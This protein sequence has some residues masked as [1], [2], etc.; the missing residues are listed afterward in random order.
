MKWKKSTSVLLSV[1]LAGSTFT[2]PAFAASNAET[3]KPLS[4]SNVLNVNKEEILKKV[5]ESKQQVLDSLFK[6][7]DNVRV[8]VEVAGES[9]IEYATKKNLSYEELPQSTKENL[10]NTA[11]ATQDSVQAAIESRGIDLQVANT[12]TTVI[13]GF[14]GEVKYAD[15]AKI[16]ELPNVTN[17]QISE[18]YQRPVSEP[19]MNTSH[20]FIQS[21]Q[22]WAD[23]QYKGEGQVIAVIDTGVDPGHKDFVLS[24]D[25]EEDLTQEEV[26]T[27]ITEKGLPGKFHTEKVPYGYN[28]FDKNQEILDLGPAASMHGM[29]V[30]GTT[31][32]NGEIKGVAPEAQVLAMKVFSNDPEY[33]STYEDIYIT[34][35]DDAIELGADVINMSLGSTASFYREDALSNKAITKATQNGIVV[36]VSAGNAGHIGYGWSTYPLAKNPDI[37]V[38][39]APGLS[40]DSLQVAATGNEMFLYEHSFTVNGETIKGNG[41]D[42]WT[43]LNSKGI[44]VVS[45]GGK[46]GYPAD[47]AGVDIKGKVVLVQR[48]TLSFY[49]K[50]RYATEAGAAGIIVYSQSPTSTHN[51]DQGGWGFVPFMLINNASGLILEAAIT[52][53]GGKL[54]L[55]VTESSKLE[56]PTMGKMTDFTSWGTTPTLEIKPEI[57]AP[58]GNIY[59]TFQNNTYGYMSGTSMAAPHVAGGSAL[60]M[61]FL[62]QD[63]P[64]LSKEESARAAK[65]RLM[66]TAKIIKDIYNNPFSPRRQG[67]GMM[68]TYAAVTTPVTVVRK[69]TEVGKVELKDF[70]AK[71]FSFT[72]EATND[73][74]EAVTYSVNTDVLTDAI[75]TKYNLTVAEPMKG[76]VVSAPATIEVPA[77]GKKEF[78]ISV[79]LTNA[80]I[81][82][83]NAQGAPVELDLKEDIFVEGFVRLEHATKPDL[84]IPYVGFYGKWDRPDIIDGFR[85]LGEA[86]FYN[87]QE[88]RELRNDG[89][90]YLFGTT[91]SLKY[92]F[93]PNGDNYSDNIQP[94]M[95]FLRNAKEVEYNILDKDGKQLRSIF[96][97]YDTRKS[98]YNA[99]RSL[100]YNYNMNR[101]WDGTIKF[102]KVPDGEYIYEIKAVLD[103]PNAQWQTKRIPVIVDTTNPDLQVTHD[104]VTNKVSWTTTEQGS[105]VRGYDVYVNGKSVLPTT[106]LLPATATEFVLP[107]QYKNSFVTVMAVDYANNV[108]GSEIVIGDSEIPVITLVTPEPLGYE[109][110]TDVQVYGLVE[111]GTGVKTLKVNGHEVEV[112]YNTQQKFHY[113]ETVIGFTSEG[114]KDVTIEATDYANNTIA[115]N[116]QIMIDTTPATITVNSE[117]PSY[118]QH[119]VNEYELDVTLQDNYRDMQFYINDN[120]AYSLYMNYPIAMDGHTKNLK[121]TLSLEQGLNTFVLTLVDLGGHVTHEVINIYKLAED[122]E[123]PTAHITSASA[124]PE[125]YVSENRPAALTATSDKPVLWNVTVKDPEGNETVL[126]A[127]ASTAFN[128]HYNVAKTAINGE[129][130]VTFGG[131][132]EAG[133]EVGVVVKTFTVYNYSVLISNVTTLNSAG[134]E[135]SVYG[136]NSIVNI[137]ASVKNLEAYSVS[138]MVIIQVL[139]Q[140]NRVI[141]KSFLTVDQLNSLNTNGLGVQLPLRDLAKGTYKVETY[142]WTGWDMNALAAAH[143]GK[144]SFT[145]E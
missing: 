92:A 47:Y 67:A 131:T 65:L 107:Q 141:A 144:V 104:K 114:V 20:Q 103:Y 13:N 98:Y 15:I 106:T 63:F 55:N 84:S 108:G 126:T 95:S 14:S 112:K 26:N 7:D 60:V 79:D 31:A 81:P 39:G 96:K 111:D 101:M 30:A 133:Q 66:N 110:S 90:L 89:F 68:Q 140:Q 45:L 18:V 120:H 137:K 121:Q 33:A 122:E 99:A 74:S 77:K 70:T 3:Q 113:F 53:A 25:T 42:S 136:N 64:S 85:H 139:D 51:K 75:Y 116:R 6:A 57:S 128:A 16:S 115:I 123:V 34:A 127:P 56:S 62:K 69:G 49:D 50:N 52:A 43:E 105:G 83:Y 87:A 145:V 132:N 19:N 61:Q 117:V 41:A 29:H 12:F 58:G 40:T 8:I 134:E 135:Q 94:K 54:A 28:Y 38:V 32:A 9:A 82:G 138:P 124:T 72:L 48:G 37:G 2:G 11:L 88:M 21:S 125:L 10:E 91:P 71:N 35:L 1:L 109:N 97:Q 24:P 59:S 130:T 46:L 44:E 5:E 119:D 78:T 102:E 73:S 142:V 4:Y 17:V 27:V 76:A 80:K 86:S 129:Y 93:S 118:V 23:A 143:K 36:S 100:P 22:T